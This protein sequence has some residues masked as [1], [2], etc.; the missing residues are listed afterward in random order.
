M[1][2]HWCSLEGIGGCET[3]LKLDS[4]LH[5]T[6][7]HGFWWW[8]SHCALSVDRVLVTVPEHTA[9]SLKRTPS[10]RTCKQPQERASNGHKFEKLE[11]WSLLA[12][13]GC[14]D[15]VVIIWCC[16]VWQGISSSRLTC[17]CWWISCCCCA[18]ACIRII[19]SW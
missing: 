2:T 15:L 8:L 19:V 12:G 11:G 7:L 3:E 13:E 17:V 4:L 5:V 10:S 6:K 16:G 18:R 14:N 1:K 9:W